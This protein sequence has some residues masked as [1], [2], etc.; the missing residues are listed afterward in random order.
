LD[1]FTGFLTGGLGRTIA[2]A[3]EVQRALAKGLR[4]DLREVPFVSRLVREPSPFASS[5]DFKELRAAVK[6]ERD[7]AVRDKKLLSP[8]VGGLWK[9]ANRLEEY[10]SRQRKE[11][12]K[13]EGE[14]QR[15]AQRELDKTLQAWNK[16][17]RR[18]LLEAK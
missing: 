6:A 14:A 2:Q 1:H 13:L 11:I 10:R 16:R 17:A 3:Y 18:A 5:A 9:E 12:D 15:I 7:R 4:P 8:E